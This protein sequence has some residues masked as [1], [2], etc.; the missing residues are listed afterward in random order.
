[1]GLLLRPG[2]GSSGASCRGDERADLGA[3][4]GLDEPGGHE[5]RCERSGVALVEGLIGCEPRPEAASCHGLGGDGG[6]HG[7]QSGARVKGAAPGAAY[8]LRGWAFFA[9]GAGFWT[10]PR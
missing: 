5:D 8:F 9:L 7:L 3:F 1:M 2:R 6:A 10:T 4:G